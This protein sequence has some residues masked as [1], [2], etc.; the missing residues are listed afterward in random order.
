MEFLK[1]VFGEAL[2]LLIKF[3]EEISSITLLT[4]EISLIATALSVLVGLP[5]GIYLYFSNSRFK[6]LLVSLINT[7]LSAPP[8]V[9]GLIVFLILS[10]NG[11]FGYL[12]LLYTKTAV[13]IAEVLLGTPVAA[14]L[15]YSALVS[16]PHEK[17]L[18]LLGYG[19]DFSRALIQLLKEARSSIVAA[20]LATF[21]AIISEVGA[22]LIVG[23]NI[24]GE[25][26]VLTSSIVFEVR[27]GN[28]EKAIALA[29]ILFFLSFLF[30]Y[31]FTIS[32]RKVEEQL[33]IRH[34]WR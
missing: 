17:F 19:T 22:V 16:V 33:W 28:Y 15:T 30:N 10:R 34:I 13:I 20:I 32:Q 26:R 21:G 6:N 7:G 5:L 8:V 14:S 25:T 12:D 18:Q 29:A 11:P 23:G 1:N 2:V 24:K 4:I 9:V 31:L 27:L 3:P